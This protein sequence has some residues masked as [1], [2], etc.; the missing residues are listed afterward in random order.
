MTLLE[1]ASVLGT[2]GHRSEVGLPVSC[3]SR[4]GSTPEEAGSPTTALHPL[5]A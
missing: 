5:P 3:Q 4:V 2:K 1:N